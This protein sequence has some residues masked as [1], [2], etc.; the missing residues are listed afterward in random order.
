M[1]ITC[2]EEEVVR[3]QMYRLLVLVSSHT[4]LPAGMSEEVVVVVPEA[5]LSALFVKLDTSRKKALSYD[6]CNPV[7]TRLSVMVCPTCAL[8][9]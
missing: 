7:P 6:A 4:L 9:G 5:I 3:V 8:A 1:Q 2:E